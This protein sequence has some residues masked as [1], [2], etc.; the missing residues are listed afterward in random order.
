MDSLTLDRDTARPIDMAGAGIAFDDLPMVDPARPT[1]RW[2]PGKAWYHFKRLVKD[3]ERTEEV[4]PIFEAL[5]WRGIYAAAEKFLLS[6]EGRRIRAAEPYLPPLLDDHTALRRT[7]KGSLGHAYCDF[8]E[9]EGLSAQG[10][11]DEFDKYAEGKP[12]FH[13]KMEWYFKR[14]RDTHDL[15]HV[16]TG[17]G[18]DALGEQCVLAFTY[19]QQPSPAHLF[20]GYAGG[21]EIKKRVKGKAPIL[22]A[23]REGQKM[24]TACPRIVEMPVME[25]M[26]MPLEDVRRKLGIG[27]PVAYREVH[28]TWRAMGVDPYDLLAKAA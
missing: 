18:R 3:K 24:G 5:P 28:K 15:Q 7:P 26:A 16:L 23:V 1:M 25:L 10:L 27:E 17:F 13:D 14:L 8:M 20:L 11:V 2:Q 4:F 22:R 6:E 21:L 9:A 12:V 19:G